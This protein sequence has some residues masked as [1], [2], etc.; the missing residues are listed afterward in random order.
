M[1]ALLRPHPAGR[2]NE[3]EMLA[4]VRDDGRRRHNTLRQFAVINRLFSRARALLDRRILA[5]MRRS[6]ARTY[7]LLDIG[8]GAGDLALWTA[9]R[10]RK[11]GLRVRITCLDGDP[12]VVAYARRACRPFP[13]ITV[14][15]KDAFAIDALPKFDYAFSNHFL[16]HVETER[17][18]DFLRLVRRRTK[19]LFLM[20]DVRRSSLSYAGYSLF[21]L[22]FLRH[23]FHFH[24]GRASIRQAFR[25]DELAAA[26]QAGL[27]PGEAVVRRLAPSR[28]YVLGGPY[29]RA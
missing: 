9:R 19:R 26:V 5:D 10:C 28:I 4:A 14:M 21:A 29:R 23:S 27:P 6:P 7:T 15:H 11:L 25:H 1:R 12:E 18:P 3:P 13:D 22:V 8:A 16:H 17:L 20:N 2:P 24:D